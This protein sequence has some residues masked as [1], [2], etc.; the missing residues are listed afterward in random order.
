[1]KKRKKLRLLKR[2]CLFKKIRKCK[3]CVTYTFT[4]KR[5]LKIIDELIEHKYNKIKDT[6]DC[7]NLVAILKRML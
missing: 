4:K 5:V 7:I 2:K 6:L 3:C 1:M